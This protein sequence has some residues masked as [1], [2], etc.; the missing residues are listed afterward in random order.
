[1]QAMLRCCWTHRCVFLVLLG[2]CTA[3]PTA[4]PECCN[5]EPAAIPCK[6]EVACTASCSIACTACGHYKDIFYCSQ[7]TPSPPTPAPPIPTPVPTP[8]P[9]P[10]PPIPTPV[11]TPAPPKPTL[12]PTPDHYDGDPTLANLIKHPEL[13]CARYHWTVKPYWVIAAHIVLLQGVISL[14][15][16]GDEIKGRKWARERATRLTKLIL[17][18]QLVAGSA[19]YFVIG[20]DFWQHGDSNWENYS[21]LTYLICN[22]S[23]ALTAIQLS[24]QYAGIPS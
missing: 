5:I 19:Q 20:L 12:K 7:T 14:L 2:S 15:V 21:R 24:V 10:A 18:Y 8:A 17:F 13:M 23:A 9:T 1:M 11:P 3:V 6:Y 22:S 4:E 16:M